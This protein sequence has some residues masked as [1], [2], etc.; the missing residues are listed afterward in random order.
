MKLTRTNNTCGAFLW[1]ANLS[2]F[3]AVVIS[4]LCTVNFTST[5]HII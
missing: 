2:F 3:Y 5:Y 4:Q 1:R